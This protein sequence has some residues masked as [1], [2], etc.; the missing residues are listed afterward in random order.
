MHHP[1]TFIAPNA[2]LIGDIEIGPE[3][4]VWFG[5][6]LRADRDKIRIGRGTNIQDLSVIHVDPGCPVDIGNEVIVGH[7]CIIHGCTIQDNALIGMGAIIMNKANIGRFCIVG[8]GALVTEGMQIP[9]NS[10]VLGSPAK[11]VKQVSPEQV[12]KIKRN[13]QSYI[14]LAREYLHGKF[15]I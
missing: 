12:E 2:T 1:T 4:S 13:A 3:S 7:R 8:A 5:A 9:D 15:E 6:V 11:I 14:E 10:L